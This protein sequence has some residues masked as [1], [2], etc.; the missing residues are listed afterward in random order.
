MNPDNIKVQDTCV[1]S[2]MLGGLTSHDQ[3]WSVTVVIGV[4]IGVMTVMIGVISH[5]QVFVYP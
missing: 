3:D 1:L 2:K 4:M 5:D